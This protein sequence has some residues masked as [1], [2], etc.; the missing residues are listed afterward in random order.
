MEFDPLKKRELRG[1]T[2]FIQSVDPML[3]PGRYLPLKLVPLTPNFGARIEGL[4]LR[5]RFD[6]PTKE[7]LRDAFLRFGLLIFTGQETLQPED[8]VQF[9][10][11]FGKPDH[12]SPNFPKVGHLV[13]L[14]ETTKEQPPVTNLWHTDILGLANANLGT[15]IQIREMP[16]VGGNTA[17]ASAAKAFDCL[18]DRMKTYLDGQ[19]VVHWWNNRGKVEQ[20]ESYE[21]GDAF[22]DRHFK[23]ERANPPRTYP[24]VREHPITGRKALFVNE[25]FTKFIRYV[26]KYESDGILSFLYNWLKTPEFHYVHTWARNDV[27]IWDN[28]IMQHYALGDY[29]ERRVNHRVEFGISPLID[30]QKSLGRTPQPASDLGTAAE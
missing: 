1:N 13:D 26:H 29:D 11:N 20:L 27:A 7:I 22:Y 10:E 19:T 14:I 15:V 17:W 28:N 2:F 23:M 30:Y 25:T 4:D 8:H 6:E 16:K 21:E 18:S 24:I 12:G 5:K 3:E 9:A